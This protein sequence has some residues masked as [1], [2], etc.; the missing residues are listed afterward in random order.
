V[1]HQPRGHL[2]IG[3]CCELTRREGCRGPVGEAHGIRHTD[4]HGHQVAAIGEY[5]I[6]QIHV[7]GAVGERAERLI[8]AGELDAVFRD[9]ESI[10]PS[11]SVTKFCSNPIELAAARGE[12]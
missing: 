6:G 7:C 4:P 3:Q 9:S 5:R 10:V 11:V 2:V 1:T 8:G 12:L